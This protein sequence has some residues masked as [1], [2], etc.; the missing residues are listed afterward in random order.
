MFRKIIFLSILL[1]INI[2][3]AK[4]DIL[5]PDGLVAYYSF[6]GN[7]NDD[8]GNGND[9]SVYGAVLAA[10]RTGNENSAYY[11]D[12]DDYMQALNP[13]GL[14]TGNEA[15][16]VS[17]WIYSE[18][19]TRYDN[20]YQTIVGW[21]TTFQSNEYF[22]IERGGNIW[23]PYNNKLF[24]LGWEN[25]YAGISVLEFQKW[26][27]ITVT[28]DGSNIKL[29]INGENDGNSEKTYNTQ[30]SSY[31][32]MIGDSPDNDGW[33]ENF[34]GFLDDIRIYDRALSENEVS[35]LYA[36]ENNPTVVPEPS[37]MLLLGFGLLGVA[38]IRRLESSY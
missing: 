1:F 23:G 32:L 2:S 11:F 4:A 38:L 26:Y 21:G 24:A 9:L 27:Y 17:A 5:L 13:T 16:S 25:D 35:L 33:H 6:S 22:G 18:G 19:M 28:Y 3:A 30:L 14:A 12:G 31:G 7:A 36:Y 29:Y 34:Y 20:P 10:D 37:S 15:R 8:T